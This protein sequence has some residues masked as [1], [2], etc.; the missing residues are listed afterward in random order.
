MPTEATDSDGSGNTSNGEMSKRADLYEWQ[1]SR[2]HNG[3]TAV[4]A[5]V[6]QFSGAGRQDD[7]LSPLH[8]FSVSFGFDFIFAAKS[9]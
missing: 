5:V 9:L 4:V 6:F 8:N 3:R 7:D 1:N 2:Q